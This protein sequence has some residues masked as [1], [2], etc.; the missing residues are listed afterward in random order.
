MNTAV[1]ISSIILA[2]TLAALQVSAASQPGPT[3]MLAKEKA[4]VSGVEVTDP[5][6]SAEQ[7]K[8]EAKVPEDTS[9][10][11]D[12]GDPEGFWTRIKKAFAYSATPQKDDNKT[13]LEVN[14]L[15][16]EGR[17]LFRKGEY[18]KALDT[19][20][21]VLQRDPYNITAR[22]Y[23]KESQESLTKIT[24]DDFDIIKRERLQNVDKAWLI[25][26]HAEKMLRGGTEESGAVVTRK[27]DT[28]LQ[29]KIASIKVADMKVNEVFDYLSQNSDP[30]VAIRIDGESVK[31]MDESNQNM[32]TLQLTA[33]PLLDIVKYICRAKGL[34]YRVEDNQV[35]VSGKES[36]RLRTKAF[37]LSRRSLDDIELGADM[38]GADSSKRARELFKRLGI[39]E[40]QGATVNYDKRRNRLMV[41]NTEV[42]LRIVEAF[43]KKYDETPYQVQI[44]ARFVTIENDDL[45]Q[46]VFRHFLSRNYTWDFDKGRYNDRYNITAPNLERELTPGLRYIRSYMNPYSYSPIESAYELPDMTGTGNSYQDYLD[47][48]QLRPNQ[49]AFGDEDVR[50][51]QGLYSSIVQQQAELA[52]LKKQ[53]QATLDARN[54]FPPA[55]IEWGVLN[56]EYVLQAG[57]IATNSAN[58]E[59]T[60]EQFNV[61]NY[62]DKIANDGLG[63]V[64]DVQGVLGP[65]QWRSVI[66]ALDNAEGVH[67]IFAPKVTVKTGSKAEI[68][69]II[70]LRYNTEIEDAEDPE[71]E[72]GDYFQYITDYAVTPKVWETREYGTTLKVT[73]S[74]QTDGKTIELDVTPELSDLV[75]W[76]K[77]VSSRNN[78]FELPQFFV[79]SVRTL[80]KVNDGDTVVM[81]GLMRNNMLRTDDKVPILGDLPLIGRFWRSNSESARKSNLM[82]F[83]NAKLIDPSGQ[84][85]RRTTAVRGGAGI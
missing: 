5:D 32:I 65:A 42:N 74:V 18:R 48:L 6:A 7:P 10:P 70:K 36:Q 30:K 11:A 67:T 56:G 3:D 22:R 49:V 33:V 64:M 26:S 51:M 35:M 85:R 44:E 75:A 21:E 55:S 38:T 77:F 59:Q 47:S 17:E 60:I 9:M 82:I 28:D 63:K 68:K 53:A 72:V 84:M 13:Q 41:N 71:L 34:L 81:G 57:T 29:Q 8:T 39:P 80:V 1:R 76:R 79:Q 52:A 2:G 25:E 45:T 16:V 31:K 4:I 66:Y 54:N 73:P 24:Y 69:D 40:V 43:L 37:Q 15:M 23:I 61:L 62:K 20:K 46:L 27:I 58:L 83:I 78:V 12:V 19:F 14:V 50:S